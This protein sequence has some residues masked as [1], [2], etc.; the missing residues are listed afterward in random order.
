MISMRRKVQLHNLPKEF[1]KKNLPKEK[2]YRREMRYFLYF[3]H[4]YQELQ[5]ALVFRQS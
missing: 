5:T 2:E 4:M 3:G 1:S